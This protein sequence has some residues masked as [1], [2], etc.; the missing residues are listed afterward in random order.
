VFLIGTLISLLSCKADRTIER[1]FLVDARPVGGA[2]LAQSLA[3]VLKTGFDEEKLNLANADTT[4]L[5]RLDAKEFTIIVDPLP[6]DRCDP[7]ASYH[8]SFEQEQFR[9]DILSRSSSPQDFARVS[10]SVAQVVKKLH[11]PMENFREC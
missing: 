11:L 5:Y 8:S 9:I 4:T 1:S 3:A 7:N 6:D 2:K 10:N